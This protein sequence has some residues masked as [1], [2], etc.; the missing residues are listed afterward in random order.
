MATK[1][2][3][4]KILCEMNY[5]L[6]P[7]TEKAVLDRNALARQWFSSIPGKFSQGKSVA[8]KKGIRWGITLEYYTK[9]MMGI[10]TYCKRFLTPYGTGLDK[11]IPRKGYT[12]GNVVPCCWQC[13]QLKGDRL[14][15][16]ETV[17]AV[18]ALMDYQKAQGTYMAQVPQCPWFRRGGELTARKRGEIGPP[19]LS[20]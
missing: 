15:Y 17:V 11:L 8:K 7:K 13:N 2:D 4:N 19:K 5:V 1:V 16:A 20:S 3:F 12:V 9:I 18:G 14:N 10:C 6:K